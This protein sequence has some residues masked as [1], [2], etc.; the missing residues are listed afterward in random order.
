MET[1]KLEKIISLLF[2]ADNKHELTTDGE[3]FTLKVD[4]ESIALVIGKGGNNARSLRELFFL[5]NKLHNTNY[6]LQIDE[7]GAEDNSTAAEKKS[8][9][10]DEVF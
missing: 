8:E 1:S 6:R 7:L 10:T 9:A 3:Q 4:K 5:Y 2:G